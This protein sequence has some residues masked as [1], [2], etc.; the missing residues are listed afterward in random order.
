MMTGSSPKNAYLASSKATRASLGHAGNGKPLQFDWSISAVRSRP[1]RLNVEFDPRSPGA[2]SFFVMTP[3]IRTFGDPFT[4]ATR[5][6]RMN[7]SGNPPVSKN[8]NCNGDPLS[9]LNVSLKPLGSRSFT[10]TSTSTRAS[11]TLEGTGSAITGP[12]IRVN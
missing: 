6:Q 12:I 8:S 10:V 5:M 9:T 7:N 4:V 2:I 11:S 3:S 1:S